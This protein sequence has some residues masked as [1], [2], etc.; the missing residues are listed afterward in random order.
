MK[1][2]PDI[3]ISSKES[4]A[5]AM[6]AIEPLSWATTNLMMARIKAPQI[7]NVAALI[8]GVVFVNATVL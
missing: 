2:I 3:R 5:D 8:L 6:T 7:E 1:L 4:I